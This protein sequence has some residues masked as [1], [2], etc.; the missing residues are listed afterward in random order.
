MAES[1]TE[2]KLVA[3]NGTAHWC[4]REDRWS[5]PE[6]PDMSFIFS[7]LGRP[8][9]CV[10]IFARTLW[11]RKDKTSITILP[12]IGLGGIYVVSDMRG[13]G[14]GTLMVER[15]VDR[16]KGQDIRMLILKS[17]DRTIY[18]RCGFVK[19]K[20]SWVWVRQLDGEKINFSNVD[21]GMSPSWHF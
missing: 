9:G 14:Y 20:N 2:I 11:T 3:M 19:I 4:L 16:L 17:R 18:D 8:I 13:K 12:S 1:E 15:V 21:W 7:I 10:R 6:P 5:W